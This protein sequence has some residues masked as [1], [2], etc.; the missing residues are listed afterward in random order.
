M[1]FTLSRLGNQVWVLL[2]GV[3]FTHLGTYM[4]LPYLSIIFSLEKGLTL[5]QVGLVLGAGSVAYL[6]G[7]LAAGFIADR[8]GKKTTMITGLL[9][10]AIGLALFIWTGTWMS[11][12][13]TNLLAGIGFG[14]YMPGAKAGIAAF[15]T[16]GNK[17][18]AFS[19][20]GIAANIGVTVGPV[21][22]T[23]LHN[24]SSTLLFAGASIVYVGLAIA[25][26][27]YLHR[28]CIGPD[29]P[30]VPKARFRDIFTDRPFLVFSF[31]TIFVWALF[32]Q[33]S[34]ALPLRAQQIQA[35]HNIG[36]IWT[37]TS[38]LIIVAQSAATNLFTKY[39][40]PLTTMALGM[41]LLGI[42]LGTVAF[43]HSFWHLLASAVLFTIGE[44][45]IM[46]TSD[47]IVSDLAKPETIS[48]YFGVASFVFGAG[49][50][51]GN[52][53]GGRLMQRAVDQHFLELPWILYAIVG[54]LLA[55]AYAIMS[56]W[57]RLSKPLAH[58]LTERVGASPRTPKTKQKT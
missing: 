44:M 33:F 34:L 28:D 11:L 4:L 26:V 6:S 5:S 30:E 9:L 40:H 7:S 45:L 13:L 38:I 3:L 16:E 37:V 19:Y 50:A 58:T 41:L 25:H 1:P 39:L 20:R 8:I 48:A 52:V 49:E 42:A 12:F 56:R 23:F 55:A 14:L 46:P 15:A 21:I 57:E 18:T 35:A 54:I 10:R 2:A 27:F 17:T 32:T 24:I 47:A 31:A 29:C 43:S 51:L 36:M 53:G 22:G